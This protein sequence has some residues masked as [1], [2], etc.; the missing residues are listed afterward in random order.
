MRVSWGWI[1]DG[2]PR[3]KCVVTVQLDTGMSFIPGFVVNFVLKARRRPRR[4]TLRGAALLLIE[5]VARPLTAVWADPAS[6]GRSLTNSCSVD[7]PECRASMHH[8]SAELQQD[9][10]ACWKVGR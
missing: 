3:T 10:H 8:R 4:L 7:R 5:G 6:L 2:R 1:A 9:G